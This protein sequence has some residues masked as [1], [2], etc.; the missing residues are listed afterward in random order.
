[1]NATTKKI[2]GAIVYLVGLGMFAYNTE[3]I[4]AV[5]LFMAITGSNLEQNAYREF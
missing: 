2:I 4:L 3:W 1:M 5:A